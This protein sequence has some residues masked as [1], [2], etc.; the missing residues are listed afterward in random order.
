M[1]GDRA[2]AELAAGQHGLLS[3]SQALRFVD[4]TGLTRRVRQGSL[5]RAHPAVYRFAGAPV[6]WE[7]RLMAAQLAAGAGSA[8]SHRSAAE[9]WGLA[10][11][12]GDL[13]EI[14]VPSGRLPRLRHVVVHRSTDLVASHVTRRRSVTVTNPM[15]TLADLGAVCPRSVVADALERGLVARL[16][17]VP[18]V[19]AMVFD[20]ARPGRDGSGVLRAVVD[21]RALRAARPDGLLEPRMARLLRRYRLP[22]AAFQHRVLDDRGRFVARPDFAFPDLAVAIEVDG[23]EI[24][25]TPAAMAADFVRQN[26]L[27]ALGWVVVRF[28]WHQVV[29]EP[30]KVAAAIDADL[31][32]RT[33][34]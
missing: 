2:L 11:G 14:T 27:Q 4:S 22:Q 34:A 5:V 7:Q 24:H 9:L 8:V 16:F 10:D 13:V 18:S 17:T 30:S 31:R 6:T 23:F 3:R 33:N 15:R 12:F 1:R 25:G 21:D 32:T 19:E 29:R 20:V 26:A 28:T